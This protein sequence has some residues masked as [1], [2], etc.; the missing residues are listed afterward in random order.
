MVAAL[1]ILRGEGL[2]AALP[3][4]ARLRITVFREWPYLYDGTRAYEE[5]YLAELA[6]ARDAVVVAAVDAGRIVGAATA[7]PLLQ[8]T[9]E[10]APLFAHQDIDP[11]R[12]FYFGE[13]VLLEPWRGAGLGHGFFD[14]RDAAA[15]GARAPDGAGYTHA[16]FCAVVRTDDDPRRPAAYSPLDAF[17]RRRGFE[18]RPGMQGSYR[19]REVG[20]ASETDHAMQFWL[21]ALAP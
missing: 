2:T 16:A 3:D 4:L 18:P 21:K 15:R 14:H 7:A 11:V 6:Q 9:P 12:V 10:F 17:W 8:H 19:W 5:T 1:K 20:A 13:S